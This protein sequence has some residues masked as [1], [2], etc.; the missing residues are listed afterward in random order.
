MNMTARCSKQWRADWRIES[1]APSAR[2]RFE[3]NEPPP[4]LQSSWFRAAR[5][6][7]GNAPRPLARLPRTWLYPR[8]CSPSATTFRCDVVSLIPAS[9]LSAVTVAVT[10]VRAADAPCRPSVPFS[11]I[12]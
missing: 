9:V 10:C 8:P 6:K 7:S 2:F 12:A 1:N 5:L 3:P 11:A 4:L